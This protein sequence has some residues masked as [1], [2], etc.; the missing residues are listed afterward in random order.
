MLFKKK[1]SPPIEYRLIA[2]LDNAYQWLIKEFG[3]DI[4]KY[5]KVL[6]RLK[7]IFQ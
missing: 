1:I 7:R 4:I 3:V 2:W 5:K 6:R